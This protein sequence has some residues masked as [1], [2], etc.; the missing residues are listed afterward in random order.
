[1]RGSAMDDL[2][3]F[4]VALSFAGE[5]RPVAEEL[6]TLLVT[7]RLRV[8][9]DRFFQSDLWGKDL[10][11]HIADVYTH[12]SR[13]CVMVVSHNDL[14]KKWTT[15]ERKSAQARAFAQGPEYILPLR[16]DDT[17]L[18]GLPPTVGYI[19]YRTH[20]VTEV[21]GLILQKL[22]LTSETELRRRHSIIENRWIASGV[23]VPC[24][25][26]FDRYGARN[27]YF[28]VDCETAYCYRCFWKLETVADGDTEFKRYCKRCPGRVG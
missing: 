16:L 8:F 25:L 20:S 13:Y 28:C 6:A 17:E 22:D 1:M 4:D 12:R 5:D 24:T 21:V 7:R 19:D 3:T 11:E 15:H 9:Y 26:C 18:P 10:Y 23:G 14:I 27:I 2:W